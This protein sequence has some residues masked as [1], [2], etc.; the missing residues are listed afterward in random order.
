[1]ISAK[2]A[3]CVNAASA[4]R[5]VTVFLRFDDY[6]STSPLVVERGI[7]AALR[8]RGLRAT[9]AVVP[10]LTEG[11]YHEAGD[12]G[13]LPLSS[14]KVDFL[15]AAVDDGVVDI[16]LHGW[17][18]R[19]RF[20]LPPHSEFTGLPL[21][22]QVTRLRKGYTAMLAAFGV[23]PA[24]FVPPWNRYD[25]TTLEALERVGVRCISANRYGPCHS[26]SLSFVPIVVEM[27][28]VRRAVETAA[29]RAGA[30]PVIGVLL[31]PYDFLESGDS[32]AT[33]SLQSFEEEL[34]WL[35]RQD[36]V[37]VM[38]ITQLVE[39]N[40]TLSTARYLANQPHLLEGVSPP[41]VE[42]T[43]E[44]PYFASAPDARAAGRKRA[45]L[46]AVVHVGAV[47][48][49]WTSGIVI[50]AAAASDF[51]PAALVATS[52]TAVLGIAWRSVR[53]HRIYFRGMALLSVFVG[54]LVSGLTFG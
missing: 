19:T 14:D 6:C 31:H 38:S 23:A 9:F 10:A 30:D 2:P 18:H 26:G 43:V 44:T 39:A 53:Q 54:L 32:R 36:R 20:S 12:R 11:S 37:T 27:K 25:V 49:G 28:D 21:A 15:R 46:T 29:R 34:E 45:A 16:A 17:N 4:G 7:V 48:C 1:M 35:K 52:S 47:L 40:P 13:T 8:R 50:L 3:T 51:A 24:V 5:R 42:T 22:E 33:L 41:F